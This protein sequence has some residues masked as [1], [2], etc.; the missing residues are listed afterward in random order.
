MTAVGRSPSEFMNSIFVQ[1][2]VSKRML[3]IVADLLSA[4]LKVAEDMP[5]ER[6]KI[7]VD[8]ECRTVRKCRNE[9]ETR[10]VSP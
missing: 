6:M 4:C 9:A 3:M 8:D 5:C 7:F 1:K 10:P 2:F